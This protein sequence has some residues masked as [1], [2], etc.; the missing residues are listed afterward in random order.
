MRRAFLVVLVASGITAVLPSVP[1]PAAA[2]RPVDA[3][4]P[5]AMQRLVDLIASGHVPP[6]VASRVLAYSAISMARAALGDDRDASRFRA[7]FVGFPKV[8]RPGPSLDRR[9]AA[10]T[11]WASTARNLLPTAADRQKVAVLRDEV[12]AGRAASLSAIRLRASVDW[13]LEVSRAVRRWS[14]ADGFSD[15]QARPTWEPPA[16]PGRWVP[17]PPDAQPALQ[18][19]WGTLRPYLARARTC[20]ASAPVAYSTAPGSRYARDVRGVLA[21]SRRLTSRQRATARF[22]A[23]DRARTETISGT[24]VTVA[25][26]VIVDEKLDTRRAALLQAAVT[27]VTADSFVVDWKAKYRFATARPVT[28]IRDGDLAPSWTP[29]VTTPPTPEYPS[30]HATVS[31]SAARVLGARVGETSFDLRRAGARTRHFDSFRQA[32]AAATAS[33]R[34]GG[35]SLDS[36]LAASARLGRCLGGAAASLPR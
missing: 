1:A 13:G 3:P 33:R 10:V 9:V 6:P 19:Y 35:V 21:T 29:A 28:V 20:R 22:W 34:Y 7:A 4:V 26:R 11:A 32:A 15:A 36:T 8:R 25:N 27:A 17:T 12:L 23:D 16:G 18:P 31:W 30:S 14:D 2:A 24:W 5:A